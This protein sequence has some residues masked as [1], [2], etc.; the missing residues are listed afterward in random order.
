MVYQLKRTQTNKRPQAF[1]GSLIPSA[2]SFVGGLITSSQQAKAQRRAL[3]EQQRLAKQQ[4]DISNQNQLASTLNNY[5]LAQQSYDDKDYNLKYRIGGVKRLGS[6]NIMI[7][8]GGT[9]KRIGNNT[10]LLRGGSHEDINETGQTGIGIN[11]GGNEIEAEGGEVAQRKDNSLRI[12]SAQPILGGISPAEAIMRGYNKDRVFNAQQRFK[13]NN[14]IKDDGSQQRNGGLTSKDRGSSKHP[15][16]SVSSKDFAGGG[17]SYPIPTK[18]DAIDALRLAGLHGRSDVRSKV[19]SKYPELRKKADFGTWVR[20]NRNNNV[21]ANL[22]YESGIIDKEAWKTM[23]RDIHTFTG[24]GGNP[25]NTDDNIDA[26]MTPAFGSSSTRVLSQLAKTPEASYTLKQTLGLPTK[27][28]VRKRI[29]GDIAKRIG[30]A[31]AARQSSNF[32]NYNIARMQAANAEAS[33]SPFANQVRYA[34]GK[35]ILVNTNGYYTTAE[36][37]ISRNAKI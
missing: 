32:R 25:Y 35:P 37:T 7:T 2:L 4:L 1:W 30:V 12:Y 17:R 36:N 19:Y 3:E 18:A 27:E 13:K 9:A 14:G 26:V 34:E 29:A 24:M 22:L 21:L 15:Y 16:P 11:V 31:R 33:F 28:M 23:L 20:S 10:Y 8:D 5:A 6:K